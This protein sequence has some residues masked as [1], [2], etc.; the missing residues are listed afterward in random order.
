VD[1]TADLLPFLLGGRAGENQGSA[2]KSAEALGQGKFGGCGHV[3]FQ[4]QQ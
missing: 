4:F 2:G 1:I 3:I